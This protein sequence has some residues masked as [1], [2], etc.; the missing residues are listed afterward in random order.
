MI[1]SELLTL[2]QVLAHKLK[3]RDGRPSVAA[4]RVG[5]AE[6]P[7]EFTSSEL[8]ERMNSGFDV[9]ASRTYGAT[10]YSPEKHFFTFTV[11]SSWA[12]E[13]AR[14]SRVST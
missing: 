10:W 9:A 13:P 14:L 1:T 6:A 3:R 5:C 2:H 7:S 11:S 4:A 8:V 12:S